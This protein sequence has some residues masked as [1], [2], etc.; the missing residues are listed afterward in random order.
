MARVLLSNVGFLILA[1]VFLTKMFDFWINLLVVAVIPALCE[2]M[3][4]EV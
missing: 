4:L 1:L 3:L 2:E